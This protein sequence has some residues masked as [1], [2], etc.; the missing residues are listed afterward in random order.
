MQHIV[1]HIPDGILPAQKKQLLLQALEE[2]EPEYSVRLNP[3]KWTPSLDLPAVPWC[4]NAYYLA[5]KPRFSMDPLWHA[6]AYYVQEAGSMFLAKILEHLPFE[7]PPAFALDLC[8]APGG[9]T[10]LMSAGLPDDCV[11]VA[12]E[13]TSQRLKNLHENVIKWGNINVICSH[14]SPKD[15]EHLPG[16]FDLVLA[17]APCSGEGLLRRHDEALNQWSVKLVEECAYRQKQILSSAL[18]C[19]KPGGYL[20]YSTCTYNTSENE[21]NL[22]WLIEEKGMLP[23][24][25]DLVAGNDITV[26][27]TAGNKA[28][29]FFPGITRSEGFFI[30]VVQKPTDIRQ[31]KHWSDKTIKIKYVANPVKERIGFNRSH[32]VAEENGMLKM[33][34]A[35]VL[36]KLYHLNERLKMQDMGRDIGSVKNGKFIPSETLGFVNCLDLDEEKI[37]D[38][39]YAQAVRFLSRLPFETGTDK[40]GYVFFRFEGVIS[41][42]GNLL[43]NRLNNY[44]PQHWRILKPDQDKH[45]SLRDF[46]VH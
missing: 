21:E 29:R 11:I 6:G 10:T 31:Q 17:D 16:F 41:G 24:S 27:E 36:R 32:T 45:F 40:M 1:S 15:F 39:D 20:I 22:Q 8:A 12:N 4:A 13:I 25:L 3:S 33:Y 19:I 43:Q 14:N 28:Y 18:E 23:V 26:T 44:Y 37:L 2:N 46:I 42:L 34:S 30:T 9:K 5:G 35:D 38:L 7:I